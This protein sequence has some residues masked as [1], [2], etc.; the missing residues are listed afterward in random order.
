M[1]EAI[2]HE[3]CVE[4]SVLL[5]AEVTQSGVAAQSAQ[6]DMRRMGCAPVSAVHAAQLLGEL[7]ALLHDVVGAAH[8]LGAK[9]LA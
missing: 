5:A 8:L 7:T 9:T 2:G 1:N 4:A 3:I 6:V